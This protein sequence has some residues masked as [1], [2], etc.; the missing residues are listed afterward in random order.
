M[1]KLILLLVMVL[2]TYGLSPLFAGPGAGGPKSAH[3]THFQM[4][5]CRDNDTCFRA[6]G[7]VAYLSKSQET[8]TASPANLEIRTAKNAPRNIHCE[9]LSFNLLSQFLLCETPSNR[10]IAS[11]AIDAEFNISYLPAAAH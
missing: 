10:E 11:V 2:V 1:K 3:L 9:T 4:S 8:L 7:E 5:Q 6:E